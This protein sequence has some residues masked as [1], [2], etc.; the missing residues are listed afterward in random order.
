VGRVVEQQRCDGRTDSA[1]I[2]NGS[3]PAESVADDA[4]QQVPDNVVEEHE[5]EQAEPLAHFVTDR[6]REVEGQENEETI[7][8]RRVDDADDASDG[9]FWLSPGNGHT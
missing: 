7:L 4:E 6:L 1:T 5:A 9:S 3:F 2:G 8:G